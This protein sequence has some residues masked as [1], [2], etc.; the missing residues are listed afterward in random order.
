MPTLE[1]LAMA[2]RKSAAAHRSPARDR[3]VNAEEK[4]S[5]AIFIESARRSCIAR[6]RSHTISPYF[7]EATATAGMLAQAT[8]VSSDDVET[9][10]ANVVINWTNVLA[11][12]LTLKDTWSPIFAVS[13]DSLEFK[14]PVGVM[15]KKPSSILSKC[16][17]SSSRIRTLMRTPMT[18]NSPPRHPVHAAPRDAM[19]VSWRT[20]ILN[21]LPE[22][23][24]ISASKASPVHREIADV[25]SAARTANTIASQNS[26]ASGRANATVP[27]N[28]FFHSIFFFSSWFFSSSWFSTALSAS[29]PVSKRATYGDALRSLSR[30][31]R[32]F[33]VVVVVVVVVEE[34]LC[35]DAD[36]L[37]CFVG[38]GVA[39]SF[40]GHDGAAG[41]AVRDTRAA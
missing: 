33:R 6:E 32:R 40:Q 7:F 27:L 41:E 35:G 5:S 8:K 19:T 22:P 11:K 20:V 15:S 37:G 39:D 18:E 4:T 13:L 25:A 12:T 34:D 16:R 2:S 26:T 14:S 29:P 9:M 24:L 30:D 21:T 3:T 10:N 23:C 38:E 31:V 1:Y 17:K 36:E 28:A